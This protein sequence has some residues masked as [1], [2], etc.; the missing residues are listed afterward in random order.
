MKRKRSL[1]DVYQEGEDECDNSEPQ[2]EPSS[3]D[4]RQYQ[5]DR[6]YFLSLCNEKHLTEGKKIEIS[7]MLSQD[8]RLEQINNTLLRLCLLLE[9]K[10][11][12]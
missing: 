5:S 9:C 8:R 7:L 2:P 1:L 3:A 4:E 11:D 12:R 6:R 10:N